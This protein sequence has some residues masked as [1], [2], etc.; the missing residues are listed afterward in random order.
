MKIKKKLTD[1]KSTDNNT[2]KLDQVRGGSGGATSGAKVPADGD[3]R[4][5]AT[6]LPKH[7]FNQQNLKR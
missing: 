2:K 1:F 3:G 6:G 7:L 4:R 5:I